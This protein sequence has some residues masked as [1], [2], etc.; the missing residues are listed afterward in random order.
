MPWKQNYTATDEVSLKDD[1]ISWPGGRRCC[2]AVNVDLSLARGPDGVAP[3]DLSDYRA[4]FGL[5]EGMIQVLATLARY[6]IK[7]TFT[8]PAAMALRNSSGRSICPAAMIVLVTLVPTFA[9]MMIGIARATSRP[10]A[11]T[12]PTVIDVIDDELCMKLVARVPMKRPTNGFDV[13]A[14]S[15]STTPSPRR[16]NARPM[17]ARLTKNA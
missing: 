17:S 16:S 4:M 8:V 14:S 2:V 1:E 5:H 12:R 6:D 9:P 11:A 13:A 7:A 10:P 3:S 15:C